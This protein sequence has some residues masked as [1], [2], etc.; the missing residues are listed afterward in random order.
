MMICMEQLH[1]SICRGSME[2]RGVNEQQAFW[3]LPYRS[4]SPW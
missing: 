2:V 4:S 1:M 3:T